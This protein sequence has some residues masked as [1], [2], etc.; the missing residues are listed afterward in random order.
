MGP[1]HKIHDDYI[2]QCYEEHASRKQK[3]AFEDEFI[4]Y[5]IEWENSAYMIN[6]RFSQSMT[7][8]FDNFC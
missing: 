5:V 7:R 8:L 3:S 2:K 4:R 1:C 6:V